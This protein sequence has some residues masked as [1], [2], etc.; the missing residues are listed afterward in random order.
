MSN[1]H[2][3]FERLYKYELQIRRNGSPVERA[4]RQIEAI[5]NKRW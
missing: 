4:R 1:H 5:V 3:E 2:S